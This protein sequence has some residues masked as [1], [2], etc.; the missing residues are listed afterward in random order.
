MTTL[1]QR[2]AILAHLERG[3]AITPL[4][5]LSRFG[6]FRLGARIWELKRQGLK[7]ATQMVKTRDGKHVAS[8]RLVL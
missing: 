8:Y 1:S 7:V 4:E 2:Q 3:K 6:C 5:A